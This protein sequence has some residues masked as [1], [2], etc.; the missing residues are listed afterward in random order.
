[1]LGDLAR[2]IMRDN[3]AMRQQF[4]G[5]ASRMLDAVVNGDWDAI[6]T[7]LDNVIDADTPSGAGEDPEKTSNSV[8][9]G[10]ESPGGERV[11][12]RGNGSNVP[13]R[14]AETTTATLTVDGA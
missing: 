8:P 1:M 6:G 14:D 11:V 10:T 4:A 2:R 9:E 5:R 7:E 13:N 12:G 3:A